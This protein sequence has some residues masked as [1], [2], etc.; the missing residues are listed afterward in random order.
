M[1]TVCLIIVS[2]SLAVWAADAAFGQACQ[3]CGACQRDYSCGAEQKGEQPRELPG[4]ENPRDIQP[5]AGVFAAPPRSGAVSSGSRSYGIGGMKIK[6]PSLEI[7][8]PG[9]E[10]PSLT[11]LQKTPEM[12]LA[13]ARAP[14]IPFSHAVQAPQARVLQLPRD[15]QSRDLQGPRE[16]PC[17]EGSR[18]IEPAPEIPTPPCPTNDQAA[19]I[20]MLDRIHAREE[21]MAVQM[22]QLEIRIA[23][24]QQLEAAGQRPVSGTVTPEASDYS[25]YPS[26]D[27]NRQVRW[28][29]RYPVRPSS[30]SAPAALRVPRRLPPDLMP[31][32][33]PAVQIT[34]PSD[35]PD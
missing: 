32:R 31:R 8:L 17:E 10:L 19:I 35:R 12:H 25:N 4:P 27:D 5:P 18:D 29:E 22:Q 24:L 11:C 7:G 16:L 26:S 20:Q 6:F 13:E 15:Q 23:R 14:F 30:H 34:G 9:I 28:S 3:R 33:L 1:K 2:L 21:A